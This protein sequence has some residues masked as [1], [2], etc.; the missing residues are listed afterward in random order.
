M[1]FLFPLQVLIEAMYT[2][3][4][5]ISAATIIFKSDLMQQNNA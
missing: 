4:V 2:H 3:N 1:K 5:Y